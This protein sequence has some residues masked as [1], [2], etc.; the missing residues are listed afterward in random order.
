LGVTLAPVDLPAVPWRALLTIPKAEAAASFDALI[1]QGNGL[2]D[3][4]RTNAWTQIF[5]VARFLPAVD[6]INAN[7]ARLAGMQGMA[8]LFEAFDVIV[9]PTSSVQL[10]VTNLTGHPALVLPNGFRADGTPT[11]LTFLGD[12]F[13]EAKMLTL[14]H[15]Y[16]QSTDWHTR[17]PP[18]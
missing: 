13:G 9:A 17:H 1:R 12:L 6:Y 11:S 7:R 16:Q 4:D 5:R 14:A 15:A 8:R 18:L 10:V 2:L 3:A